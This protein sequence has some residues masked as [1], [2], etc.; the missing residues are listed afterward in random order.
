MNHKE[1]QF[2]RI[3]AKVPLTLHNEVK[4]AAIEKNIQLTDYVIEALLEKLMKDNS[5]KPQEE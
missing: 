1:K 4:I 5:Y 2:K 3:T